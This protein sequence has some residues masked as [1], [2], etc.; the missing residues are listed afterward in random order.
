M[1][2]STLSLIIA[3]TEEYGEASEFRALHRWVRVQAVRVW[4]EVRVLETL[5]ERDQR[6]AL[7]VLDERCLLGERSL[8]AMRD[9]LERGA[10]AVVPR[11]LGDSG[12]EGLE[13]IRTLS[14]IEWAEDRVLTGRAPEAADPVSPYAAVLTAP[15]IGVPAGGAA[16]VLGK[17]ADDGRPEIA[18]MCHRFVDYY[19]VPR[20]DVLPFLDPSVR[21]VLE[22]GCGRGLTGALIRKRLGCRVTGIELNPVAARGAVARLDRIIVG[23]VLE[24]DPGGAFDAVVATEL[25]EHLTDQGAFLRRVRRWLRP[26][27]RLVLSVPNVGH[28]SIVADLLAGRWDYLPIGLLCRTHYRFFTRRTLEQELRAAGFDEFRI[29]PQK[30]EDASWVD[31][32]PGDLSVDRESLTTQGFYVI[33]TM[34]E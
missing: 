32:L 1:T 14:G 7:L 29:I 11:L 9:A 30:T 4:D 23:D 34:P 20:E 21:D 2:R 19:G 22:I 27:G 6:S 25:F 26:G 13:T 16:A 5:E 17:I 31:A 33:V 18:G 15:G 24:V 8:C 28:H 12:L 3:S 10:R